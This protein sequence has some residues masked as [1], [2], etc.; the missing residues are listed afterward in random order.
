M[1]NIKVWES[2]DLATVTRY[3]TV[4]F[5]SLMDF[6]GE[7]WTEITNTALVLHIGWFTIEG[8]LK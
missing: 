1:T 2:V 4:V 8:R 7:T 5:G 3:R 6:F